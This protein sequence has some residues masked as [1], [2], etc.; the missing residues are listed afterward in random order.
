MIAR[1]A[2]RVIKAIRKEF[3]AGGPDFIYVGAPTEVWAEVLKRLEVPYWFDMPERFL[4][5]ETYATVDRE[6]MRSMVS[7]AL[8]VTVDTRTSLADWAGVRDDIVLIPHGSKDIEF[9][10]SWEAPRRHFYYV[11]SMNPAV[12]V[13][14]LHTVADATGT[15]V[16]IIGHARA[17]EFGHGT[18]TLGWLPGHEIPGALADAVA[19][20]VPYRLDAFTA[21]VLP[22]KIYD[23]FLA[24]APAISSML[25]SLEDHFGVYRVDG[26]LDAMRDAVER[27]RGL[28]VEDRQE[29]REFARRNNWSERFGCVV[30]E[31]A[32]RGVEFRD[33]T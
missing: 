28:S 25:P 21:G 14:F 4:H 13:A 7:G 9:E 10:P 24:G 16:R 11:G 26:S 5:S 20:V 29:L 12:D 30:R 18:H 22:T 1:N 17:G 31:L 6:S 32:E 23:Y 3:G 15:D 33:G 27:A 2:D 8:L 19:G